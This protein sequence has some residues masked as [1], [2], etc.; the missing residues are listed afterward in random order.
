MFA[1]A[2]SAFTASNSVFCCLIRAEISCNAGS[3]ADVTDAL[4]RVT[5]G[6]YA[7]LQLFSPVGGTTHA[8]LPSVLAFVRPS[9]MAG[10]EQNVKLHC[11]IPA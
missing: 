6:R 5:C 2:S 8:F 9:F 7:L 1:L 3:A 11:T 10:K 4:S